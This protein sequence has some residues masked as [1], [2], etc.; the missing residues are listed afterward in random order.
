MVIESDWLNLTKIAR[1]GQTFRWREAV[2]NAAID[3]G[4]TAD[5]PPSDSLYIIPALGR[6]LRARQLSPDRVEFAC[7][8][9]EWRDVWA[10]Y[11]DFD[12]DYDAIASSVDPDDTFLTAACEAARGLR[13]L[14][15]DFWETLVSFICSQN[16][17]IP[18]ITGMLNRICGVCG[19]FPDAERLRGIGRGA[20]SSCGLGYR[21]DYLVRAAEQFLSDNPDAFIHTYDY[22]SARRYLLTYHGVGPKVAD[23][24]CLYGL[25]LTGAFPRDVWV[26][27]IESK[28]YGG[29]FPIEMY[30]DTAGVLQLF[31]FWYERIGART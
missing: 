19:G 4:T 12:A 11:F 10:R 22:E 7:S 9:N 1:S 5:D 2:N 28:Y 30:P 23:C 24:V 17:N 26:K 31:M 27:R 21:L 14:R 6:E 18:R 29:P 15:Q 25:G 20:L 16:N 3:S 13:M 8:D